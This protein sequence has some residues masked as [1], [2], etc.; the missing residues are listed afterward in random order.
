[1]ASALIGLLDG[2]GAHRPSYYEF[3]VLN[4]FATAQRVER[5]TDGLCRKIEGLGRCAPLGLR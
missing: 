1:M 5:A 2:D 3:E 4:G